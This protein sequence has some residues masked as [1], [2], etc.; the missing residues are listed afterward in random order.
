MILRFLRG[1]TLIGTCV[2]GTFGAGATAAEQENARWLALRDM[3]Y[4]DRQIRDA[5]GVLSLDAPV[6]AHD[7]AVVPIEI[8][9]EIPQ[10]P[11]RY[12]ERITLLI[13]N[14]PSPLAAVF[15]LTPRSG[16]ATIATRVRVN[17]YTHVRAIAEMNDG[18]LYMSSRFVKASGGCS[19]PSAKDQDAAMARLGKLRLRQ[20]GELVPNEPNRAQL[21]ISHPNSSGLQMDQLT[22]HY[23]PAHFV[24]EIVVRYGN[25]TILSVKGD[26][27]LSED[28][29]IHF[30]YVPDGP[31]EISVNVIDTE[32]ARFHGRWPVPGG[33]GS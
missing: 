21:L 27:S 31:G 4:Q 24:R 25:E 14:N 15:E 10:T 18:E 23:V 11:E 33:A 32:N 16:L 3:L 1:F 8:A 26:I 30:Y 5:S 22:R 19:A 2:L 6:R 17:E 20:L 13:D 12:I 7:A 29:S 9:A 28:P